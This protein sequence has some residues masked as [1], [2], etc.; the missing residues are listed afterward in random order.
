MESIT[1]R[2]YSWFVNLMKVLLPVGVLLTIGFAVGWP[3]LHSMEKK[4]PA[5]VDISSPEIKENRML[6]PEYVSTDKK[7]QPVRVDAEWAK[8]LSDNLSDLVKPHGTIVTEKGETLELNASY[9][10]YDSETKVLD[11][12]GDVTL[13]STDGYR[14]KTESAHLDVDDKI[15]D[16][17]S[18]VEGE[19]PAGSIMG[20][21]GFKVVDK[22][23][24]KKVITLKGKSRVIINKTSAK[25][26]K[27]FHAP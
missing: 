15:I 13:T 23:H 9:G 14:L 18:Y 3:Y 11:L 27:E 19:G 12:E 22:A 16:G 6:K 8:K 25:S 5:L 17:D 20:T 7:G 24:G 10:H 21:N 26:K 1:I 2:R 4:D